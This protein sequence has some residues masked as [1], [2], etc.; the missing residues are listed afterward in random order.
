MFLLPWNQY[1]FTKPKLLIEQLIEQLSFHIKSFY[2]SIQMTSRS[3]SYCARNESFRVFIQKKD[4]FHQE[5]A[6][7]NGK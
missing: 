7:V 2:S 4:S 5:A 1:C 6:H 3:E